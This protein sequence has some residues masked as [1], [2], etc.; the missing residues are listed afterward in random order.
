[1]TV[2]KIYVDSK[3]SKMLLSISTAWLSFSSNI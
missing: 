1:M 2:W 3:A